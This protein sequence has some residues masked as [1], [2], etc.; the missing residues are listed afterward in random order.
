MFKNL[1]KNLNQKA[2]YVF[3]L[4]D[5]A[6]NMRWEI[7][8]KVK[9]LFNKY[10]VK[11][12]LGVIPKNED[13]ELKLYPICKFNFWEEMK[14]LSNQGWVIA[15]HGYEHLYEIYCK[16]NDYLGHGGNS[17]FVGLSYD[18][19]LKKLS[20]GIEIFKKKNID[21]K[22]FFAPNHTFD[23][24]TVKA[25]KELGIKTIIDGYGLV[26]YYENQILFIPQLFY[27]LKSLPIGIQT[28]Q[29]HLNY[30]S[31]SDYIDLEKF[32]IKNEKEIISYEDACKFQRDFFT[33]KIIR[34]IIKKALQLKR[35]AA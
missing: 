24:N 32:I 3:R 20:S 31:D 19:Q 13:K 21:I 17:E 10:N 26:P 2:G 14:N 4:D 7:M 25:C 15:M 30:F 16:K 23:L 12:I 35:L 27:K 6:P 9:I 11:P 8:D 29:L 5:I 28:I 1:L 34:I 33:D 18:D 22:V